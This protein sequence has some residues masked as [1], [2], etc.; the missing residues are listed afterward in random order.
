[1]ALSTVLVAYNDGEW[2]EVED[3]SGRERKGSFVKMLADG[4]DG[5]P[6]IAF[7]RLLEGFNNPAHLHDQPGFQV[8]LSGSVTFPRH[9]LAAAAVH[10]SDANSGYALTED[11]VQAM[12]VCS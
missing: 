10:Y 9:Q 7:A 12:W 11:R 1:M 2:I 5:R 4:C 8:F 6:S 3:N